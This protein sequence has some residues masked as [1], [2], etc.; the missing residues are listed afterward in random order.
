MKTQL[1]SF[2]IVL[3]S[4][5]IFCQNTS[6]PDSNFENFLETR[7]ADG[8][9][10]PLG[11][12]TSLGDGVINGMVPTSK[13]NGLTEIDLFNQSIADLTGIKDFIS[14]TI[15]KARGNQ[16]TSIDVSTLA[17]TYLDIYD[18]NLN[19]ID[20][21]L[22]TALEHLNVSQNLLTDLDVDAN[23]SLTYL[24]FGGNN[25]ISIDIS[26]NTALTV[27]G[28]G[29]C[30][31][32]SL[33]VSTNTELESLAC[34]NNSFMTLDLS[35]NLKLET[36]YCDGN[37]SLNSLTLP[38]T[39]T[40]TRLD[41]Y[42]SNLSGTLDLTNFTNLEVLWCYNN[43]FSGTLDLSNNINLTNV[44][45][46]DNNFTGITMPNDVDTLTRFICDNNNLSG[47]LN[48]SN[49]E[50]L[51][52]VECYNNTSL[53]SINLPSTSTLTRLVCYS[54]GLTS[55]DASGLMGLEYIDLYYCS[56]LTSLMLPPTT[57]LTSLWAY[58]T[59]LSSLDFTNNTGLINMDIAN[60]NFTSIDVSMLPNLVQFYCNESDLLTSLNVKNGNNPSMST[61]WAQDSPF[62]GCI[63]V[64]NKALS[65]A[66]SG[67]D[68][69]VT[70]TYEESC[71]F[72]LEEFNLSSIA[73]HPNPSKDIFEIDLNRNANYQLFNIQGQE[74]LKGSLN[75]GVNKLNA[76]SISSGL[77]ILKVK[78]DLGSISK[79]LIKR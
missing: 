42:N 79:K 41:C 3:I 57:T 71:T 44:D 78:S 70:A 46:G 64:D 13:I 21:S 59:G 66:Y 65:E 62:L 63:Q 35:N 2:A 30:S 48:V 73:I 12:P 10:V 26:L 69:D 18:S 54:T 24:A 68:K 53:T 16:L 1:L 56:S 38:I 33:D 5:F 28:A 29:N 8:S 43:N 27:L 77:Y 4:N 7:A 34:S 58:T 15:L 47:T 11:D 76:S 75:Q 25:L 49:N 9:V 20:V 23:T 50:V 31:L 55:L 17:L 51:Q 40:L 39:N 37:S 67:W 22:N 19:T 14:L 60:G 6:I 45:C 52:R 36:L 32:T 61:M 74:V 72:S